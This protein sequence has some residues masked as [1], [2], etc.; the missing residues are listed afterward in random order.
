M[1]FRVITIKFVIIFAR[2]TQSFLHQP[3]VNT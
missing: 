1:A 2:V 3:K